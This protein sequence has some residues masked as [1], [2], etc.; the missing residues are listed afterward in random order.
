MIYFRYAA[1]ITSKQLYD[2]LRFLLADGLLEYSAQGGEI[3]ELREVE[4][5]CYSL[6][7]GITQ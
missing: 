2:Y 7:W 5:V 1:S 6:I 4:G 3:I